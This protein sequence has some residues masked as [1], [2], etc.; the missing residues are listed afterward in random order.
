MTKNTNISDEEY[1]YIIQHAADMSDRQI[2]EHLG[3]DVRTVKKYR[4]KA[5]IIKGG[6]GNIKKID[7]SDIADNK[8][9]NRKLNE[10]DRKQF[11]K[12]ELQNSLFYENLKL[13]FTKEELD[14]YLEEWAALCLQ[15]EDIVTTERRQID[16]LIKAEIIGNRILRNIKITEDSILD[17][18]EEV[19]LLRKVKDMES[20]EDAQDRDGELLTLIRTLSSQS[21]GMVNDYGKNQESRNKLLDN[22]NARRRDRID[23]IQKSGISFIDMIKA[24][25][26][27]TTKEDQGK[28]LELLKESKNSKKEKWRKPA[29][30]PDGSKDCVLLD[31]NSEI[32]DVN[33]VSSEVNSIDFI[34]EI[35]NSPH[36]KK[37]AV[38]ASEEFSLPSKLKD[39]C[40]D[41]HTVNYFNTLKKLNTVNITDEYNY[42]I[43]AYDLDDDRDTLDACRI[44]IDNGLFFKCKGIILSDEDFLNKQIENVIL[45]YIET[46]KC[47]WE[48]VNEMLGDN[49]A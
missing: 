44:I 15:F 24:L 29:L 45:G 20:D 4:V 2:S 26:D 8:I 35:I 9:I 5:G 42:V 25:N 28:Y 23:Q 40:K 12:R 34:T 16:E 38:I 19:E 22:L 31:E 33:T 39:A 48:L 46:N 36:K 6:A 3:R 10:K 13:Q 49:N 30:F 14:F 27:K 21:Q 1:Q 32:A 43:L 41:N 7:L 18:Q 11:F 17:I 37:I 47:K